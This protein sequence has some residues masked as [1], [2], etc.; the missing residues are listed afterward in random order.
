MAEQFNISDLDAVQWYM[1]PFKKE[2]LLEIVQ[3][4]DSKTF[5]I[6]S[7][8]RCSWEKPWVFL[9]H[10]NPMLPTFFTSGAPV[11]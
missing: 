7:C 6:C 10:D 4:H 3:S 5:L 9:E 11:T 2:E 8:L 1:R